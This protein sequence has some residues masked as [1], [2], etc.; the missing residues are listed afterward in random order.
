MKTNTESTHT[1]FI[2][3]LRICDSHFVGSEHHVTI[4]DA[5]NVVVDTAQKELGALIVR[6]VNSHAELVALVRDFEAHCSH[7]LLDLN[8]GNAGMILDVKAAR[9][10]L[11]RLEK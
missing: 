6:A 3:P 11:A 4:C 7:S 9:A 1:A 5:R 10:L 8:Q 2:L